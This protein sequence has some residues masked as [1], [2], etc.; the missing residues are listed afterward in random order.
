MLNLLTLLTTPDLFEIPAGQW[1]DGWDGSIITGPKNMM[2][3]QPADK[4][5]MWHK[6]GSL[7][8]TDGTGND[9]L[10]LE[11]QD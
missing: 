7:L 1:Q 8:V 9:N 4:I 6:I 11:S 5:P 2:V 3:T 10:C